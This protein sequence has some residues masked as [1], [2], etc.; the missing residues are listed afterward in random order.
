MS[1]R[2]GTLELRIVARLLTVSARVTEPHRFADE[3]DCR[4]KIEA[5]GRFAGAD[6][7][8]GFLAAG[9]GYIGF[10]SFLTVPLGR[11]LGE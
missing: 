6:T 9:A 2:L 4:S 3:S 1:A 10:I 5:S 8:A 11:L 7:D